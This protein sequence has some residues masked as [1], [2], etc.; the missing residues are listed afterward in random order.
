MAITAIVKVERVEK[1]LTKPEELTQSVAAFAPGHDLLPA[2]V[3]FYGWSG[4]LRIII[5]GSHV[6]LNGGELL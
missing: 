6:V 3:R 1:L 2:T 5:T 4:R